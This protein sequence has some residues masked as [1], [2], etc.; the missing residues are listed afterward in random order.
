MSARLL[1]WLFEGVTL[2]LLV[3]ATLRCPDCLDDSLATLLTPPSGWVLLVGG[4]VLGVR[5]L[6]GWLMDQL[7]PAYRHYVDRVH[8]PAMRE[9]LR[10]RGIPLALWIVL[11]G[12]MEELGY[13]GLLLP[14]FGLLPTSL[15]F[16]VSHLTPVFK[17]ERRQWPHA[18][19]TFLSALLYGGAVLATGSLWP[20]VLAHAV[21]NGILGFRLLWQARRLPPAPQEGA[22]VNP[23]TFA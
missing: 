17:G 12:G 7:L 10:V 15:L 20:S 18:L 13:R 8:Y 6:A 14:V 19:G 11:A 9:R 5:F 21:G 2:V 16:G 22:A 3:W 1:R 4:A 23:N